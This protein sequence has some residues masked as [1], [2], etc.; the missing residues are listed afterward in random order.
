MVV[1]QEKGLRQLLPADNEGS[2]GQSQK[3][4][5]QNE[6]VGIYIERIHG[7]IRAVVKTG[8]G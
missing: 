3:R 2:E 7:Q 1:A 6:E 8:V 5:P 4:A